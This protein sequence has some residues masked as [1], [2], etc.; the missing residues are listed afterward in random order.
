MI[1]VCDDTPHRKVKQQ[2]GSLYEQKSCG[3]RQMTE[4]SAKICCKP[5]KRVENYAKVPLTISEK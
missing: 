5:Y 1:P 3:K 4:R 2:T